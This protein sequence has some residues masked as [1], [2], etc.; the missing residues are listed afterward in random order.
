M[1]YNS[2]DT[3]LITL[4]EP[5]KFND[6]EDKWI[7]PLFYNGGSFNFSLKNKY[8]EINKIEENFYGKDFI[9]IK[10]KEYNEIIEKIIKHLNVVNP[11]QADGTFRATL[12]SKTKINHELE[13]IKDKNFEGCISLSF[14]TT[15]SDETKKTL[16]IYVKDIF[17]TK[18]LDED[19]EVELDKLE[20]AM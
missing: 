15:Y 4:G 1:I 12:N 17:I 2:I 9:T 19:L 5:K 20:K 6:T 10:S 16:Q 11:I 3:K 18:V 7:T 14:P 13:K 8:I